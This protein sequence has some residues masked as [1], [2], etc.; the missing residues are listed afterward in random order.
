MTDPN[1]DDQMGIEDALEVCMAGDD[2][3]EAHAP[4]IINIFREI[5]EQECSEVL[6]LMRQIIT[7]KAQGPKRAYF[8]V[9]VAC[10]P[11]SSSATL[12]FTTQRSRTSQSPS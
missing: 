8:V 12:C 9:R 6:E 1:Q 11:A 3:Y 10:L 2:E 4:A 5:S 7:D